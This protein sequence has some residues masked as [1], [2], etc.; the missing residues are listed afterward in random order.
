MRCRTGKSVE[1]L[2]IIDPKSI[3]YMFIQKNLWFYIDQSAMFF[4]TAVSFNVEIL[5]FWGKVVVQ[6]ISMWT[7]FS[8]NILWSSRLEKEVQRS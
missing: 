7:V 6:E 1:N 2:R 5:Q 3:A 8:H 4:L